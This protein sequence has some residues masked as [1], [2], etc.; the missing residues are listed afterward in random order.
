MSVDPQQIH[1]TDD[2]R[3]LLAT[4]ADQTGLPWQVV[5]QQALT[6]L[7]QPRSHETSGATPRGTP[8]ETLN[9][10]GLIGCIEDTAPDLSTNK[11]Y[12]QGLGQDG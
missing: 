4:A 7:V 1:L 9:R 6:P 11:S 5:L 12:L 2:P 10:L 3:R 8:Y